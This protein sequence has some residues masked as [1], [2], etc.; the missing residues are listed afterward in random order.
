MFRQ[1]GEEGGSSQE[2]DGDDSMTVAVPGRGLVKV[3]INTSKIQEKAQAARAV[4]ELSQAMGAAFGPWAQQCIDAFL[5]LVSFPY[6]ADVRSTAAQTLSAIFDAAC[7]H[8]EQVGTMQ[9]PQHYLPLLAEAISKQ[10]AAESPSDLEAL[11]AL[12]DS[13]SEVL[14]IVYRYRNEHPDIL[15]KYSVANAEASVN[16]CMAA[17]KACLE[18]RSDLTRVLT[19]QLTGEDEKEEYNGLLGQEEKLLTPLVDSV[20]YNL[21]FFRE[22]FLPLFEQNVLPTLGPSLTSITDIRSTIS[23]VLLF[24]DCVEHCGPDAAAKYAPQLLQGI[25]CALSTDN[26]DLVQAAVYGVAQ[27]ARKA[28]NVISMDQALPIVQKLLELTNQGTKDDGDHAYLIELSASAL[29]SLTLFGPFPDLKCVS[30]DAL[31]ASF[32]SQ[33]PIQQD[34]G[35]AKICHAQFCSLVES[36]AMDLQS[37]AG[38]ISQICGTILAEVQ[39]GEELATPDTCERLATILYQMQQ[40]GAL[41]LGSLDAD[42]QGIVSGVLQD[43]ARSRSHVVVTP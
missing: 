30:R 14:Y 41:S 42:T 34:N 23:A 15:A 26:K 16:A 18:R 32:V 43:V 10:I 35:E 27:I 5:P 8:G 19:G 12:G 38:H 6:S 7:A 9:L 11:Y 22:A 28:P 17:L 4:Y 20:G 13:L 40:A 36:G 29:A 21:K 1:E 3:T 39:E 25:S 2:E 33:L 24:D 31:V 37:N